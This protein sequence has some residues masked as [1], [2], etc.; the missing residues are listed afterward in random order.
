MNIKRLQSACLVFWA[1]LALACAPLPAHAEAASAGTDAQ[2]SAQ[3]QVDGAQTDEQDGDSE[4]ETD[5]A[6]EEPF[7]ATVQ[8]ASAE[9]DYPTGAY[10]RVEVSDVKT[11]ASYQWVA[12]DGTGEVVLAGTTA[13]SRS[14]RI[15][16]TWRGMPDLLV[17]CIV[18]LTD[19]TQV[20][21]EPATLHVANADERKTVLY[22]GDFALVP[23]QSLDLSATTLGT[24][25]VSFAAD[26]AGITLSDVDMNP[27][28][29]TCDPSL[30]PVWGILLV[31]S[32]EGGSEGSGEGGSE[33]SGEGGSRE[34][35]STSLSLTLEGSN[36]IDCSQLDSTVSPT[37]TLLEIDVLDDDAEPEAGGLR[38]PEDGQDA[39]EPQELP[40]VTIEGDGTLE[41]R[42]GRRAIL[43]DAC[44]RLD[45]EIATDPG[46]CTICDAI[47]CHELTVGGAASLSLN[48]AG[49]CIQTAGDLNIESGAAVSA[50]ATPA[51]TRE[52]AADAA[53]IAVGGSLS[54]RGATLSAKGTVDAD[55]LS[56]GSVPRT[57]SCISYGGDL[58]VQGGSVTAAV[59][60][61][62]SAK[63]CTTS[64]FGIRGTGGHSS[65]AFSEAA[66]VSIGADCS[67]AP[68]AV[69]ASL[70][71]GFSAGKDVSIELHATS[72]GETC[73]LEAGE[74]VS[75][76]DATFDCRVR[77]TSADT[78]T[79]GIVCGRF[80]IESS[81]PGYNLLCTAENG[82]AL[83]ART[84]ERPRYSR[85]SEG[86]PH[87]LID[88]VAPAVVI[89]PA[90]GE[91]NVVEAQGDDGPVK[92][93]SIYY[94][95]DRSEPAV[96]VEIG[97]PDPG[98]DV[99]AVG[100]A[101]IAVYAL[102]YQAWRRR[103]LAA[104]RSSYRIE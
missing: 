27:G 48:A 82:I 1:V 90:T 47:V 42:G 36:A 56:S 92:A 58:R 80:R 6:E 71:G 72:A 65:A 54:S 57:F 38:E 44:L 18:T 93:E 98:G 91:V 78:A 53:I 30:A 19:G 85:P 69:G 74:L 32:G 55:E 39:E 34:T 12:D 37:A 89:T 75:M 40:T 24:G 23:G 20:K 103:Q 70:R 43:C 22:V 60:T 63:A 68:L 51:R 21:T 99:V 8:P 10:F 100:A 15:P 33:D 102:G 94:P 77:S 62:E 3:E 79:L 25:K 50:Q 96:E 59:T 29:M 66:S 67:V 95:N 87:E 9:V 83:M 2:D 17:S 64:C 88:V 4:E 13:T 97:I 49:T 16:S 14:L 101:C 61:R 84:D 73:G 52:G 41:L 86:Y 45:A 35:S 81:R 46:D 11:V 104:T 7:T 31:G 76:E 28:A 5:A 26:G